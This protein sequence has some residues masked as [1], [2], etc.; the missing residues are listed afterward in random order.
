MTPKSTKSD[1]YPEFIRVH[2]VVQTFSE[3]EKVFPK[4]GLKNSSGKL[5]L[6]KVKEIKDHIEQYLD[7]LRLLLLNEAANQDIYY[8]HDPT[9]VGRREEFKKLVNK[10]AGEMKNNPS[11]FISKTKDK[12]S[13]V[14]PNSI[15]AFGIEIKAGVDLLGAITFIK[16]AS[17]LLYLSRLDAALT[18]N[19]FDVLQKNNLKVVF[20]GT[21]NRGLWDIATMSMR[22]ISSCQKWGNH[23]AKAL[24]GSMV[25][26]Y[27]G[28]IYVTDGTDTGY[29][30]N[31]IRRSV[32]RFVAHRKT[33]RPAI[34]IERIYPHDY[35]GGLTD[36]ITLAAFTDFIQKKTKNKFPVVY[37]E[38]TE[39]NNYFIPITKPVKELPINSGE[40]SYRDSKVPY[41]HSPK[42]KDASKL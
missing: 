4:L 1:M 32:V 13:L 40:R 25:D 2:K 36:S 9:I 8:Y 18:N 29:G 37:G 28:I 6:T 3:Q 30:P 20:S 22:G 15:D 19:S 17:G 16:T 42:Y 21:G 26:P 33:R 39:S 24:I 5:S 27:A 12:V 41:K 38:Y 10:L 7:E 34:M 14:L 35:N 11:S 23:H 31:M